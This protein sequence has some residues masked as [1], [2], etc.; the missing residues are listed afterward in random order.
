[1]L[2]ISKILPVFC[3]KE[4][5]KMNKKVVFFLILVSMVVNY[6]LP[7]EKKTSFQVLRGPYMGMI[8]PEDKAVVFMDRLISNINTPEMCA[9]FTKDGKEFYYNAFF[10]EKWSIY[11]TYDTGNGWTKPLPI[12]FTNGFIDRD[13]TMSPD[14]ERIYFGSNRPRSRGGMKQENLDIFMSKRLKSGRWSE[15]ITLGPPVNTDFTENYPSVAMNGNIYYFSCRKNGIG[16]CDIFMSKLKKNKYTEPIVLDI[17][18]NSKQH[19]W[20]AYIA[21][22]ESYIIFSSMEREDSIGKQDLYISYKN[23][24]GTWSKSK[25]M[26]P[27]VNSDNDEICPSVSLDGK[28]FFFTSRRRG[29]ADIFWMTTDIIKNLR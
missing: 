10:K 18:V 23:N 20:D 22:D 27:A 2:K 29:S 26:G 9:A 28:Y 1:M 6:L 13:F 3:L 5:M 25:N 16:G 19:D 24:N 21:P 17:R 7:I 11:A 4:K 8:A 15:P 12:S 14:G